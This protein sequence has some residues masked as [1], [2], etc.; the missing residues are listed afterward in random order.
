MPDRADTT[1]FII[2]GA[3]RLKMAQPLMLVELQRILS[4]VGNC[5]NLFNLKIFTER[6][7]KALRI[8]IIAAIAGI[9]QLVEQLT[10]NQ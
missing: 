9:A 5:L 7:Y 4:I 3:T 6:L 2:T 8:Y 1:K 10:C